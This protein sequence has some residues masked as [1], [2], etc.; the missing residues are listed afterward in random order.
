MC[1]VVR[2]CAAMVSIDPEFASKYT[3]CA[4]TQYGVASDYQ[5]RCYAT[6]RMLSFRRKER[7]KKSH[8]QLNF[9]RA[10]VLKLKPNNDAVAMLLKVVRKLDVSEDFTLA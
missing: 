2:R 8:R 3:S 7:T 6:D 4:F 9:G 1:G 10:P 5:I